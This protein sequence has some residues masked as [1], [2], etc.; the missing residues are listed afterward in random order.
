MEGPLL[1]GTCS[2]DFQSVRAALEK[3]L[4]CG[5]ELGA[6]LVVD[7]GGE[8]VVDL[9]GGFCD[10]AR[11]LPWTRDTIVNVWSTTKTV[12]S[13]AALMLADRGEIDL[14]APVATYWPEFAPVANRTS[15]SAISWPIRP[16][17]PGGTSRLAPRTCMTGANPLRHWRRKPPGGSPA[18]P[19]VTTPITRAT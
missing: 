10:E 4:D 12:T 7:M 9:W 17:Y 8:T 15:K 2:D 11:S 19:P 13:L 14:D 18:R 1:Q 5:E 6:S 16:G 3:N